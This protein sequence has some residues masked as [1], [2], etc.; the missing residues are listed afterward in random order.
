MSVA[1]KSEQPSF[2]VFEPIQGDDLDAF[3][4][5]RQSIIDE[6]VVTPGAVFGEREL[7]F[8]R[9]EFVTSSLHTYHA[10]GREYKRLPLVARKRHQ[11]ATVTSSR[12][13]ELM[14]MK[15]SDVIEL[16]TSHSYAG[17]KVYNWIEKMAKLREEDDRVNAN[18]LHLQNTIKHMSKQHLCAV[19]LQRTF[20][21]KQAAREAIR[22]EHKWRSE[23]MGRAI[24]ALTDK[25][26]SFEELQRQLGSLSIDALEARVH[27][28]GLMSPEL[29]ASLL[30]VTKSWVGKMKAE[31][32]RNLQELKRGGQAA[33]GEFQASRNAKVHHIE[34]IK[35][36]HRKLLEGA[37]LDSKR[38]HSQV[39]AG[40]QQMDA[41]LAALKDITQRLAKL[42][43]RS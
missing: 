26:Q 14:W 15:W 34:M 35:Q 9:R 7:F 6:M 20:R 41:V 30:E 36:E 8:S 10:A 28:Q 31:Q 24:V 40:S 16:H 23:P 32:H 25:L 13:A 29:Q 17:R 38:R 12:K 2:D 21:R 42:E 33:H 5:A 18:K 27:A 11:T 22:A 1:I 4:E 43:N 37:L 19:R 39:N 3:A